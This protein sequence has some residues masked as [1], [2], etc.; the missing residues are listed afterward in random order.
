MRFCQV[1]GTPLVDAAPAF[2]P[3][4]T[5]VARSDEPAAEAPAIE[6]PVEEPV[7]VSA[8]P[9]GEPEEVLDLPH[10]DPLRT[11]YVSEDEMRAA[12]G[13]EHVSEEP[14]MDVPPIAEPEP[15]KFVEPE[16]PSPVF[17]D[18]PSQASPFA[19]TESAVDVIPEPEAQFQA[20]SPPIPSPFD[21][22]KSPAFETSAS[23]TDYS[24]PA[25]MI[26]TEQP[27]SP[28]QSPEPVI[29]PE[30]ELPPFKD[31][32]PAV[33]SFGSPFQ[34]ASAPVEWMPPPA[35][36]ASWQNQE[37][38]QNTPFQ[39]PVA[40]AEGANKTLAIVSLVCGITSILCCGLLTGIPAI[41]TGY[42]AKNNV[43]SNPQEYGGRGLAM[44]G[45]VLGAISIVLTIIVVILQ[46]FLGVL[47]NLN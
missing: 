9:I 29:T 11:M 16:L 5:V 8:S 39:P 7:E 33:P 43:D 32:E 1:D 38:G 4:A 41:I 30:L 27:P 14:I 12:L 20:T 18:L 22:P 26:Q 17:G 25:T 10:A 45:M 31:P 3:Y 40:G 6:A 36:E 34:Q 28:F 21:A 47:G 2:D 23:E 35:P 19:V 44:A 15:P 13:S 37:I 24:E 46:I 42:M